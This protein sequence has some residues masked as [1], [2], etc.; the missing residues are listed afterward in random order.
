MF[1]LYAENAREYPESALIVPSVIALLFAG[2]LFFVLK[3]LFKNKQRAAIIS[4]AVILVSFSYSRLLAV[5]NNNLENLNAF[6]FAYSQE[7]LLF[8]IVIFVTCVI[9]LVHKYSKPLLEI[10]KIL[11]ILALILVLFQF[12]NIVLFVVNNG[13]IISPSWR[14]NVVPDKK[15]TTPKNAPD[16]YYFIFDRY[17]GPKSLQDEY[18]YNNSKFFTFLRQIG[19]YVA[20][21]ATTNYP[22]TFLVLGANFNME[23]LNF[24]TKQTNGGT[25]QNESIVT[26]FIRNSKVLQ[27][28][29][30]IGY[31]TVNIGSYW[32]PTSFNP[33]ADKNFVMPNSTYGNSDLFTTGFLNTTIIAP[34]LQQIFHDPIDVSQ[35]PNNNSHRKIALYQLNAVKE[36]IQ[37]KGPKFVFAHILLPH[38][39]FVFDKNCNP[40]SEVA[41]NK[42]DHVTNYLNQ[43]QCANKKIEDL[44]TTII[45]ESKTPPVIMLQSDEGPFPIKYPLPPG[46]SWSTAEDGSLREKFPILTAYYMPGVS[47]N[48]LYQSITPVNSF[49]VVFN[50]YFHTNYPML[51]DKNYVFQDENNYYKFIDV[52]NKVK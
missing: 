39:P 14:P 34:I 37:I 46:Q 44:M 30:S 21:D 8:F 49:R 48:Q 3:L 31:Y 42:N 28:L 17:A 36:V 5:V 41:V 10:N 12:L 15:I 18:A 51:E 47:K 2:V 45:K 20:E 25:S 7:I 40:I 52:T 33:Y 23:Y 38:D 35:N 22:K 26:P 11:T 43:L 16:I 1:F 24:L 9:F 32:T 6:L 27:Y 4:S 13:G 50:A 19:F 29:K